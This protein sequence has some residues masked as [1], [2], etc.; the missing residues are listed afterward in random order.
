MCV[1]TIEGIEEDL[2]LIKE[3]SIGPFKRAAAPCSG[4]PNSLSIATVIKCWAEQRVNSQGR[5]NQSGMRR[6]QEHTGHP[7]VYKKLYP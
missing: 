3:I 7:E 6:S 5:N 2:E 4:V 1:G